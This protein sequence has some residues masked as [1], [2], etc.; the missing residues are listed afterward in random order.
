MAHTC[1]AIGCERSVPQ[2]MLMC[3][4]H[5]FRVPRKLRE[6][7]W[8]TYRDGQCNTYDPSTAYC[9]AAKAAVIAVA[10]TEGRTVD[11]KNSKVLLYD[12]LIMSNGDGESNE[13]D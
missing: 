7:V 12:M 1:H 3:G 4:Q 6:H 9:Q 13:L 8:A 2:R 10:E 11:P 5:W